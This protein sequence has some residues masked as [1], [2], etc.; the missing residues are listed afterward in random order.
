[1]AHGDSPQEFMSLR[2][3]GATAE[4]RQRIQER[5]LNGG[6]PSSTDRPQTQG[7]VPPSRCPVIAIKVRD[8]RCDMIG[9]PTGSEN[10]Y[11]RRSSEFIRR[12][13]GGDDHDNIGTR[14]ETDHSGAR[15]VL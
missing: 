12:T 15:V 4:S 7:F 11:H 6:R 9:L 14:T 13:S 1:L 10:A 5:N 8:G 2:H 3:L